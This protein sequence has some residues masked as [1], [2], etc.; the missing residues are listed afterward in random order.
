MAQGRIEIKFK[1]TGD[2]A[3][4][5]AIKHLDIATKRLNGTTSIYEKELKQLQRAQKKFN[6]QGVFGV[7]NLRN[8][9][10]ASTRLLPRLSVLRSKLLI[11]SFG[12]ALVTTAFKKLFDAMIVQ[13]QAEKKLEAALG[14]VNTALLN[15]ASALQQVTTF[16]DEAIIEVQALIGA[17]VKDEEAIKAATKATL[18]LAAAKGMDLKSAGDLVAKSLGSSTNSLSRYGIEVTGAVGS[19]ERLESLTTNIATLFGGQAAAAADTLGG[20][21]SQMTN[22]IGDTNEAIGKVLTPFVLKAT[23][24][25]KGLAEAATEFFLQMSENKLETAIRK[26]E[27][28]GEDADDLKKTLLTIEKI[29]LFEDLDLPLHNIKAVE[30]EIAKAQQQIIEGN[31]ITAIAIRGQ[32]EEAQK[33]LDK[34]INIKDLQAKIAQEI[35]GHQAAGSFILNNDASHEKSLLAQHDIHVAN[36]KFGRN[37][38]ANSTERLAVLLRILAIVAELN[39]LEGF[40]GDGKDVLGMT[41][42]EWGAM[43]ERVSMWSSSIMNIA[44]QYM[45][46]QQAQ[47][48]AGKQRELDAASNIK[49]EKK[50]TKEIEKINAK[51]EAK[52]DQINKKSKR[53]K[54]AQT[55][56]NTATGIMEVMSDKTITSTAVKIVMA[57]LV[58]AMGALQLATIDAQKYAQGGYVGGRRHSQGGTLIEAE[59]GEYVISRK[60]V[61]A[62]GIEN[63]NRINAGGGSGSVNISFAGNVM[64]KD[65]IEDEAIPQIKEAI[66]RGADIGIG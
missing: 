3:L 58:G 48:N 19:T 49:W 62:A 39:E 21:V 44:N 45:A 6:K 34:N 24:A 42:D 61:E 63:L 60:G 25:I 2:K 32:G 26:L 11:V 52:Q 10:K 38:V 27:E 55:V 13:E 40:G 28:L 46:L 33:L 50:R 29:K 7:K 56:V 65:F 1:P 66:R 35:K 23:K 57:S 8:M 4:I 37:Q 59:Q 64:S 18:D 47:L 9:D 17:F 30:D 16:G 43:E 31:K 15:Q 14:K 53:L 5:S 51:Y 54:R 20:S 12:I 36:E 41:A 22:A